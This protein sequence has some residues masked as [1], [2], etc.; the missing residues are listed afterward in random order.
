MRGK[1]ASDLLL[2][3]LVHGATP[4]NLYEHKLWRFER[5]KRTTIKN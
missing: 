2:A 1:G 5:K 4:S 3:T